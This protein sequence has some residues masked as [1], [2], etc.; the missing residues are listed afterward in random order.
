MNKGA[1]REKRCSVLTEAISRST[2][3]ALVSA[4]ILHCGF[5]FEERSG[6]GTFISLLFGFCLVVE[7]TWGKGKKMDF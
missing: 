3:C 4:A 6:S 5:S 7:M 2:L 1:G